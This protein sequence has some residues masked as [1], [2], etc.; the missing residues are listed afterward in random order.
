MA[1]PFHYIIVDGSGDSKN[2]VS[3]NANRRDFVET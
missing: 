3:V 2:D 1:L